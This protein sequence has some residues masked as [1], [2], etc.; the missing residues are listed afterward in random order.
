MIW[1]NFNQNCDLLLKPFCAEE[2][3]EMCFNLISSRKISLI[4]IID[5]NK[6]PLKCELE[7][8]SMNDEKLFQRENFFKKAFILLKDKAKQ[9]R[10]CLLIIRF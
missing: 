2:S 10:T 9:Y 6:M 7:S 8:S 1:P 5:F 3:L 4:V